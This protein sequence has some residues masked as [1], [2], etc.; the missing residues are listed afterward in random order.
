MPFRCRRP[1]TGP[2]HTAPYKERTTMSDLIKAS[3]DEHCRLCGHACL[4]R[5]AGGE[6]G[7]CGAG[8]LI[9]LS[10]ALAHYGEEPP[11]SGYG[12]EAAGSGTIFFTRCVLRCVFCQN[13][14]IS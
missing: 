4:A 2:R 14:Q 9:G 6:I 10:T 11:I 13:W 1:C 8:R 12:D 7:R 5:R 3:P